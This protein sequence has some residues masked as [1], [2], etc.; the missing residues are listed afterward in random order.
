[1]GRN[2]LFKTLHGFRAPLLPSPYIKRNYL[3]P[4]SS[5]EQAVSKIKSKGSH[6]GDNAVFHKGMVPNLN[7][8]S[9]IIFL[10]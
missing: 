2:V 1:M 10:H 4:F 5:A 7:F 6:K 9:L 8:N 3:E